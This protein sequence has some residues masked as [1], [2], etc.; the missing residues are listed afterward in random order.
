[1]VE[2]LMATVEK[3]GPRWPADSTGLVDFANRLSR[4]I[5]DI[6]FTRKADVGFQGGI[7]GAGY[8]VKHFLRTM[9]FVLEEQIGHEL[10]QH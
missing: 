10:F 4:L 9:L 3:A 2:K 8:T 5:Q 6:R 7:V 1:M